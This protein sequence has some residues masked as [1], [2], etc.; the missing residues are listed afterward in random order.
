MTQVV[1]ITGASS[2]IGRATALAFV[3]AGYHVAGTARRAERLSELQSE[4]SALSTSQGE[5]LPI[6]GDVTHA[7]SIVSAVAQTVEHFGQLDI[8]VANAG[9]GQRGVMVDAEWEDLETLLRTNIDGVLHS[10]RACVPEMRKQGGGHIITISS[11]AYNLVS[12]YAAT[13]AASKA[14]VSSIANSIRIEVT[15]DNIKVSDFLV[16]RTETEF[17]ENRLGGSIKRSKS[18]PTMTADTVAEAIV[19]VVKKPKNTVILRFFDRLLVL[20]NRLVPGIIGK[21]AARQYQ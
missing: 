8:L 16:G 11:V 9:V 7:E 12:P 15:K 3:K 2:G 13:Y 1:F 17:N 14:F 10:I 6:T 4:I 18:V 21:L 19:K 20:G 5:F